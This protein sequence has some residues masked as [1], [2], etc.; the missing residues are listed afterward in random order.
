MEPESLQHAAEDAYEAAS[1]HEAVQELFYQD[2]RFWVAAGFAIFIILAAKFIWPHI[3]RGLDG[4]ASAIK[5]QLEAATRLKDEAEDLL[6]Q[7]RTEQAQALSDAETILANAKRDAALIRSKAEEELEATITR[8]TAQ[9]HSAIERAKADA[10][11]E[12]RLQLVDAATAKAR[13]VL[14]EQLEGQKEDPAFARALS[15]IEGQLH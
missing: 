9:A 2:P 8:R 3:V 13:T 10:M 6:A 4:R 5:S 7:Y 15:A 11:A 12:I 14:A 1:G